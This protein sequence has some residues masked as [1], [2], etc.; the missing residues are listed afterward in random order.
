VR[1][2]QKDQADQKAFLA[3]GAVQANTWLVC[4]PPGTA[5][6]FTVEALLGDAAKPAEKLT[7]TIVLGDAAP[8]AATDVQAAPGSALRSLR[9]VYRGPAQ[10]KVFWAP[11]A[12]AGLPHFELGWLWVYLLVYLPAMFAARWLLRVA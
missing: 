5:G 4:C 6:S 12:W 2:S 9:L 10:K 3:D 1:L 7:A 11:L 8:P